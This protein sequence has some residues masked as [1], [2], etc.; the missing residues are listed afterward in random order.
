MIINTAYN[1]YI[2]LG[3][4]LITMLFSYG[5]LVQDEVIHVICVTLIL[6]VGVLHGSHDL[7][8]H[9]LIK[10]FKTKSTAYRL[11][12]YVG[13]MVL[14]AATYIFSPTLI[15]TIFILLSAYHFG[16]EVINAFG[17]LNLR[18]KIRG[19][20]YG[21]CILFAM[22]YFNINVVNEVLSSLGIAP[23]SSSLC[24]V[25]LVISY[26]VQFQLSLWET[27]FK[28]QGIRILVKQQLEIVVILLLIYY[29]PLFVSFTIFFIFWH[30]I[31]SV[32]NQIQISF[33]N[34][35]RSSL[36]AYVKNS[37]AIYIISILGI[38]VLYLSLSRENLLSVS[39]VASICI[40]IPHIIT[41]GFLDKNS[42]QN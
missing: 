28:N 2:L 39:I 15:F 6:S 26:I 21:L 10:D 4:L 9:S 14:I 24:K 3:A 8:L 12:I 34:V 30:S 16:E 42:I 18:L 22:F 36:F 31:P 1:I 25:V 19:I 23:L 20:A 37:A 27:I 11:H 41:I 40:S 35:S 5:I 13:T 29:I 17:Q 33:G 32:Y 38:A 7:K